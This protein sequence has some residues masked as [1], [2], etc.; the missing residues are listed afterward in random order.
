[1]TYK[2]G[3]RT[4]IKRELIHYGIF[5]YFRSQKYKYKWIPKDLNGHIRGFLVTALFL[6]FPHEK[7]LSSG[8][9]WFLRPYLPLI[10]GMFV[11][12]SGVRSYSE[13]K[14]ILVSENDLFLTLDLGTS[15]A[16]NENLRPLLNIPLTSGKYGLKNHF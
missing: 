7:R 1:M 10:R 5:F 11:M 9:K 3:L 15:S 12:R 8:Q 6:T 13:E 2:H 14:F 16:R 4:C